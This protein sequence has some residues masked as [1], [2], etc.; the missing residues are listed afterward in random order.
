MTTQAPPDVDELL[1]SLAAYGLDGSG[2]SLP[3][4]PLN[5]E[6][7]GALTR[8]VTTAKL[9]GF[10]SAAVQNGDLPVTDQQRTR[11][12][13]KH[14]EAMCHTL[15]L[16]RLLLDLADRLERADIPFR[17][18][19]GSSVAQLD[20]EDACLRPFVD[21]DLL[22]QSDN[23]DRSVEVLEAAGVKRMWRA[24]RSGFDRRFGKGATLLSPDGY[25]VD[26][27]RTFAQGPWGLTVQLADLWK[28][29]RPFDL[30]G[31]TL[32]ALPDEARLLHA[33]IHSVAGHTASTPYLPSRDLAEMLLFGTVNVDKA[34]DLAKRWQMEA[35]LAEAANTAWDL[36]DLADVTSLSAWAASYEPSALD[37][38]RRAVYRAGE[39]TYTAASLAA[40]GALPK[41][42]DRVAMAADL[43]FPSRQF[44]A[45]RDLTYRSWL[46]RGVTNALRGRRRR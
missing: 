18:L 20:Y 11:V 35:V 36:L 31:H 43:S 5:D 8:Q 29:S 7:F 38:R 16:E 22:V 34:R 17:V 13:E 33:A 46:Q 10:L 6:T 39:A 25:E 32:H 19:K 28:D 41:L 3:A 26:L 27:H 1:C 42:R 44:L 14:L 45:D 24:P 30:A 37:Q 4:A 12:G 21:V 15:Y 2:R 9:I 40:L 23:F